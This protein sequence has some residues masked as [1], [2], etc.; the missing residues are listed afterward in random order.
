MTPIL[1][2]AIKSLYWSKGGTLK[3]ILWCDDEAIK[4][5]FIAAGKALTYGNL[6]RQMADS[7]EDKP[8]PPLSEEL[9]KR[10]Y[11]EFG[12]AEE[13]YKYRDAV[14]KAYPQGNYPVFEGYN[15]MQYQIRDP[16]GFAAMLRWII[17]KNL[18]PELPFLEY[19]T[20]Q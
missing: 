7:L 15:H 14:M 19:T 4:P 11:F 6:R 12:S 16:K 8:F 10:A 1:Y 20:K 13:H 5:Y 3:K 2:F 9:Q 18:L 17:E